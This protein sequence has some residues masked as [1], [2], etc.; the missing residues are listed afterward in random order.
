MMDWENLKSLLTPEGNVVKVEC[1]GEILWEKELFVNQVPLSIDTDGSIYNGIGYKNNYRVRSGG[2]EA[3][4]ENSVCTG[5]MPFKKGQTLYI[6]P[7]FD[8]GNTNNAI[9]FIDKDFTNLGQIT[10]SGACYGICTDGASI[11]K[12]AV[13]NGVSVL[14]LGDKADSNI[15]YIRITHKNYVCNK[16]ANLIVAINQ[17]IPDYILG[18]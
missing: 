15:A 18:G 4:N 12:S 9:N 2:T 7:P 6:S 14:T 13:I 8:G 10:D 3:A 1:D 16:G 11:Y 17:K 5:F